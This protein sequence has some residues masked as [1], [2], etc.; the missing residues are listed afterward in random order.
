M[1]LD[2]LD[3]VIFENHRIT[4]VFLFIYI[5]RRVVCVVI[6]NTLHLKNKD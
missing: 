1:R 4:F 2:K 3:E 6:K 5:Y